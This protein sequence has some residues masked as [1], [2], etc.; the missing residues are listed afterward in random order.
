MNF[1]SFFKD[2]HL[3]CLSLVIISGINIGAAQGAL[4]LPPGFVA[5]PVAAELAEPVAISFAKDGRMFIAEKRGVIRVFKSG[6]LLPTPFIDISTDVNNHFEHGF[7]GMTLHP[8]F[9]TTPYVYVLYV[10]DP[11][12]VTKD[13]PGARV[14]RVE[15]IEA[16]PLRTD[17]ASTD[18]LARTVLVGKNGDASTITDPTR[19]P[20]LTC[21][22]NGARV[23]AR[24]TAT[25][26]RPGTSASGLTVPST[27]ATATL[28]GFRADRR[29]RPRGSARS[30]VS[31][32]RRA[33]ASRAIPST[34]AIPRATSRRPGLTGCVASSG[35]ASIRRRARC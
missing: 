29:T 10:Y 11:P 32:R 3:R 8:D 35:S 33:T 30:S 23:E 17:V 13:A 4:I 25:G 14:G 5:E 19:T 12:G 20:S 1:V 24:P 6:A 7:V 21:W 22:R 2:C 26:I 27:S 15:R 9:P 34:T 16:D 18:P 31:T 28:T